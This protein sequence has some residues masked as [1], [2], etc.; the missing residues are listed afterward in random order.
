MKASKPHL[1][2][3]PDHQAPTRPTLLTRPPARPA[4]APQ[5]MV[6]VCR[7]VDLC[8]KWNPTISAM[9]VRGGGLGG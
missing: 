5:N 1:P 6:C 7:E 9:R 8:T 3:T 2:G 4:P